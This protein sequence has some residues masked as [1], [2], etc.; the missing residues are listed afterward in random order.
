MYES[1]LVGPKHE[2]LIR[3][4]SR[5]GILLGDPVTVFFFGCNVQKTQIRLLLEA[6]HVSYVSARI[7]PGQ[8]AELQ[9]I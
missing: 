8:Q 7:L 1:C 2:R 6:L 5:L 4:R 9:Y 3:R